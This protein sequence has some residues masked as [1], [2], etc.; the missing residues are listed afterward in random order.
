MFSF[1]DE[2]SKGKVVSVLDGNTVQVLTLEGERH[3]ILLY[4]IDSPDSGQNFSDHAK[5]LLSK[6]VLNRDITLVM[7]GKDRWGNR[8]GEIQIAGAHDPSSEL[9]REGLAWTTEP[10]PEW[11]LLKEHAR[12]QGIGLWSDE[13]PM[14]PWLYRRQQ[15]MMQPKSM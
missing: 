6:L 1:F 14:P 8:I 5:T 7:R 2:E 10:N 9:V 12:N 11:E 4:G 3:K 15:S 13:H